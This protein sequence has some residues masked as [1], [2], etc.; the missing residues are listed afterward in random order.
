MTKLLYIV[1]TLSQHTPPQE[2][3]SHNKTTWIVVSLLYIV[4]YCA[5]R[6]YNYLHTL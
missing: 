1:S 4:F 3:L 6:H 5:R 2:A